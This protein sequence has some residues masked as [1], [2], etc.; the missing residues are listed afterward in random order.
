MATAPPGSRRTAATCWAAAPARPQPSRHRLS[1]PRISLGHGATCL[2][3]LGF[4]LLGTGHKPGP[5]LLRRRDLSFEPGPQLGLLPRGVLPH[6]G[7]LLR[8]GPL[9]LASPGLRGRHRIIPLPPYR[10]YLLR[11]GLLSLAGPGLRGRHVLLGRSLPR[12]RLSQPRISLGHGAT[13]LPGLG[14]SLLGTG[15]KP[16]PGLLRRRDLSFEPGP[17]LGLLPR[18]VL[19]HR[20][21]LLRGGPLSLTSPGLRGRHLLLGRSLPRHRL[22]QP[23]LSLGHG[24]TCLPG[25]GFSLLGTGHKPGPGL[26]RRRDLSFEPGPQLGLLPRGVLPHGGHLLR[27]GP[28]SL[29]GLGLRGRHLLLGRSLPRH[30]LS[31]PRLSLGHGATCLPGLGFSLLGTGHKPGP[32]LLAAAI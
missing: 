19:P 10:G 22:S 31:Q 2:P 20:G 16:G 12:H 30:R 27:G 14:F 6:R 17:Q 1:Q 11:R 13:C 32:G 4:S 21:H 18:G 5:G 9:S 7:H 29:T 8:R 25:L 15:H 24:T 23:R 26:L 3:G 28:L